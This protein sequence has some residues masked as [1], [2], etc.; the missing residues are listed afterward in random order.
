MLFPEKARYRICEGNCPNKNANRTRGI[1][2]RKQQNNYVCVNSDAPS[3][4]IIFRDPTI[5][6]NRNV[7]YV[8]DIRY[9]KN[10][11][12]SSQLFSPYTKHLLSYFP[13]GEIV[14]LDNFIRCPISV[15]MAT[16]SNNYWQYSK[17]PATYCSKISRLL[18]D[19]IQNLKCLIFSDVKPLIWF[20]RE[21]L[22]HSKNKKV[23]DYIKEKKGNSTVFLDECFEV[24]GWRFPVFY[25][26]HPKV[27]QRQYKRY[28][29]PNKRY[30]MKFKNGRE[31]IL[32]VLK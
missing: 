28:Y 25:F 23:D 16:L 21:G 20:G 17:K 4:V 30:H 7:P 24:K 12:A 2:V 32:Q 13:E 15:S 22:L 8:L 31:R 1:C 10:K 19:K 27:L 9:V 5:E 11:K 29:A 26:P 14:Y 6:D 3:V 18:V